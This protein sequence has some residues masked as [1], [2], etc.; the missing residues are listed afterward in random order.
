[1]SEEYV[2]SVAEVEAMLALQSK[3]PSEKEL[4]EF[5]ERDAQ[6]KKLVSL[7]EIERKLKY[8][9]GLTGSELADLMLGCMDQAIS[10]RIEVLIGRKL[11]IER[12][13]II[14]A[15]MEGM[16]S[17]GSWVHVDVKKIVKETDKA[18]LCRLEDGRQ[19]W[20]PKTQISDPDDYEE[21]DENCTISITEWIA[22]EKGIE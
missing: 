16:M 15:L 5:Y 20:L 8:R 14:R 7:K 13:R 17:A 3:K 22:N 1:M 10:E 19:E 6:V 9:T 18:F 2:P 4:Q 21:G 11:E 12:H